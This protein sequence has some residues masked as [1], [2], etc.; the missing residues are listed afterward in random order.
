ML[1]FINNSEID[2][3]YYYITINIRAINIEIV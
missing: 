2:S 1:L 3:Y